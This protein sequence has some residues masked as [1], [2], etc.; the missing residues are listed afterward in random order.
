M[1]GSHNRK[2]H[3]Q[4]TSAAI[5]NSI[6][7]Y[8][9]L[10]ILKVATTLYQSFL[11]CREAISRYHICI[12]RLRKKNLTKTTDV[13]GTGSKITLKSTRLRSAFGVLPTQAAAI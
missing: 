6:V 3:V 13:I 10:L 4:G 11:V 2:F 8:A 12:F 5:H 1:R 9:H 7:L